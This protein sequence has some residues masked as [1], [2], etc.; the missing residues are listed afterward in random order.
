M[1][2]FPDFGAVGGQAELRAIVGALLTIV[3]IFA[4]LML[5]IC[6][7]VWAISSANGNISSAVR[8]RTGFL[9]SIGAAALAGLGVTWVNFLLSVGTSI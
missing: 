5:V 8:A 3:L 2:V 6:A 7:A 1:D 9:V 4:V